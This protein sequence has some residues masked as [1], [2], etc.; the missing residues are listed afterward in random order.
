MVDLYMESP[1]KKSITETKLRTNEI[2]YLRLVLHDYKPSEIC[3]FINVR[4]KNLIVHQKRL[5][6]ELK[7]ETF[8]EAIINA[9]KLNI[10][11]KYDFVDPIVKDQGL[12]Y[13]KTIYSRINGLTENMNTSINALA[14]VILEFYNTCEIEFFAKNEKEFNPIEKEYLKLKFKGLEFNK[15]A[16]S[17][18]LAS[19]DIK[20]LEKTLFQKL[21]IYEWFNGFKKIFESGILNRKDFLTIDIYKE[22]LESASKMITLHSFANLSDKEKQLAIYHQLIIFYNLLEYD[23]LFKMKF[24][25]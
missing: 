17:L 23:C 1:N 4:E 5:K 6:E 22:A 24:N 21:E 13:A 10:I 18:K 14:I 9:F 15:I 25:P 2:L 11:D 12:I 3:H 8:T 7:S 16:K 20:G 19:K